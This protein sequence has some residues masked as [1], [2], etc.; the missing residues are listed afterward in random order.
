[1]SVIVALVSSEKTVYQKLRETK[2]D[3]A[4]IVFTLSQSAY[5]AL[6]YV[7]VLSPVALLLLRTL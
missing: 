5:L 2:H 3:N 7:A 6:V 4:S 1:M